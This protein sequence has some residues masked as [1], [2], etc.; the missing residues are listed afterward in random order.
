MSAGFLYEKVAAELTGQ[1]RRGTL[2]P[3]DRVPSVRQVRQ[4]YDVSLS[5]AVQALSLLERRGLVEAR[6][7]SGF[8]VLAQLAEE[9]VLSEQETGAAASAKPNHVMTCELIGEVV[10]AA[11][12]PKS[13]PLGAATIGADLLPGSQLYRAM[14]W[15]MRELGADGL[16]YEMPP[17]NAE[18]RRQIARLG[19]AAGLRVGPE[20]IV[21]TSGSMEA[22][23]LSLRSVTRPGDVVAIDSPIFY[24]IL[25][26]VAALGLKTAEIPVHP[27]TGMDLTHLRDVMNKRRIAAVLSIPN[28]NNPL[29]SKMPDTAKE[30]LVAMLAKADV[31]LIEDDIYGDLQHD[32]LRPL[33]AKAFDKKGLV[34]HCSSYSKTISPGIRVGWVMPGRFQAAVERLKFVNTIASATV[35]QAAIAHFLERGGYERHL[36]RLRPE[37]STRIQLYALAIQKY[38]PAGTKVSCPT[39]GFVLWVQMPPGCDA[40]KLYERARAHGIGVIPGPAF[41]S[42]V[43]NFATCLRLSCGAPLNKVIDAA[44]KKLG[45][46]AEKIR[47]S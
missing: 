45:H 43:G 14:N 26:L 22:L 41:S 42:E 13:L 19:A 24:G 38:F 44:L 8:Y 16:M 35:A 23:S 9:F 30:E 5:T 46:E 6:P 32:G 7:Q 25:E 21:I 39:G 3:G 31:P 12:D 29:G 10:A 18:L 1:I 27:V 15:A 36:K 4:Q 37:L 28:F 40:R 20:A 33:A 47:K 34:L 2:R 11:R 17:G